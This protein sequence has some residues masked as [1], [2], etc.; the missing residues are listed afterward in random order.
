MGT[1]TVMWESYPNLKDKT[2]GAT[3]DPSELQGPPG[4]SLLWSIT[5]VKVL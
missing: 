5:Q 4:S 2:L 3:V 1:G